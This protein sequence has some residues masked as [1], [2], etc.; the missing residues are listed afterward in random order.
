[1][2]YV[3]PNTTYCPDTPETRAR[4]KDLI[5]RLHGNGK[6]RKFSGKTALDRQIAKENAALKSLRTFLPGHEPDR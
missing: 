6:H 5:D 4:I 2:I 3:A 1:M